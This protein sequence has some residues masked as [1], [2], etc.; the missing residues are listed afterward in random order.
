MCIANGIEG[1]AHT[2][3][4]AP[5]ECTGTNYR[6]PASLNY[7]VCSPIYGRPKKKDCIAASQDMGQRIGHLTEDR[8]FIGRGT[9]PAYGNHTR[10]ITPQFFASK[11]CNIS[12]D[13]RHA[14]FNRD[15][16]SDLEKGSYLRGR[17]DAIIKKCVEPLGIGGW[18][19]AGK[20]LRHSQLRTL[21]LVGIIK[22]A[23]SFFWLTHCRRT[24]GRFGRL[25]LSPLLALRNSHKPP[26]QLHT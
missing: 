21:H 25:R 13:T 14:L 26:S 17:A 5:A 1:A 4:A 19:V 2:Q 24:I 20:S 10:E 18:A 12:V 8:E 3:A 16:R 6:D 9:V 23:P 22:L 15:P 11:K 7:I